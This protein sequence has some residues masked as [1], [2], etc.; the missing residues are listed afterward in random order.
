MEL[1]EVMSMTLSWTVEM[2]S[3]TIR[4]GPTVET[5]AQLPTQIIFSGVKPSIRMQPYENVK[6]V[7]VCAILCLDWSMAEISFHF[8]IHIEKCI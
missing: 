7:H 4:R 8:F 2:E 1:I 6:C 5:T 3:Y